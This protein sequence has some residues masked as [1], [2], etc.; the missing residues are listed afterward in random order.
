[1]TN[2]LQNAQFYLQHN[3]VSDAEKELKK[4]LAGNPN[5]PFALALLSHCKTELKKFSEAVEL[6]EKAV[7]HNPNDPFLFYLL[8]RAYFFSKEIPKARFAI[9]EGLRLNPNQPDLFYLR[10]QIEFY[11]ENWEAALLE[12]E[13]GLELAPEDVNLINLRAQALVKLNRKEEAAHTI[14]FALHQAPENPYSHSNK[15]WVAIERGKY[16]DA[17]SHFKEALRLDADNAYARAG[18]KEALKAKNVL[19]RGIL[20]YFLWMGKLQERGRWAFI[21]GV[22]LIYQ[23]FIWLSESY[24]EL[25][26]FL[27]PFI[28]F[29]ILFA[30]S[31]WIARPISNLFLRLHPLGKHALDKDEILGSNIAGVLFFGAILFISWYFI[32]D[33]FFMLLLGGFLGIML[34]PVGGTF[35]VD[36]KTKA[37][38]YMVY[39]SLALAAIGLLGIFVPDLN[40]LIMVFALGIFAFGWVANYLSSLATKEF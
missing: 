22:Y 33:N 39:Y 10:A 25:A 31:T 8:A 38:K 30:F 34:I 16:E 19:Y 2:H 29:Y 9:K 15:G 21:I 20:K 24:P 17:L 35:G 3:R 40:I 6:A 26:P 5:D 11:Q 18:L 36:S 13:K 27:Y 14:N 12:T 7:A 32:T 4:A 1:M 37:R 28:V 23:V